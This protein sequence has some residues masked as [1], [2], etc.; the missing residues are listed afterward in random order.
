MEIEHRAVVFWSNLTRLPLPQIR[1]FCMATL[2]FFLCFFAW[3]GIAPLMK[4]VREDLQLTQQQVGWCIIASVSITVLARL[5]V[6]RLC[7]RYGPRKTYTLLLCGWSLPVMGIALVHD[8]EMFLIFRFLIGAVGAA[9]VVTQYHTT[10]MFAPNVVGTANATAAAWGNLGG[11]VTQIA[12]PALFSLLVGAFGLSAAAGW[13]AAMVLAGALCFLAGV[14]Y[15]R[16]TQDAPDGNFSELR[17]R[18]QPAGK[19]RRRAFGDACLDL[20]VW[21]LFLACAACF[22]LELTM[23]NLSA[24]Y[25][26]DCFGLTLVGAGTMAALFG[27]TNLFARTLGGQFSDRFG[28]T[29]GLRGRVFWLFLV[30]FAEG[31]MLMLFSQARHLSFAIPGLVLFAVL[32]QMST[33]ATFSVVPFVNK[34]ALGSVAGI[35][36]AGGNVGAVAA[37]FFFQGP[38]ETWPVALLTLGAVVTLA[39]F[40]VFL[41]RFSTAAESEASRDYRAA[42]AS[43]RQLLNA[44]AM[45]EPSQA[46]A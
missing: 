2:S 38:A 20:R 3:F 44:G 42:L 15:W 11:G 19:V 30:L 7:D 46:G 13:R 32:V 22:G 4:V 6:G 40:S 45:L 28:G 39:S 23:K 21:A 5:V 17:A 10:V 29:W 31:L 12:M 18:G 1:A 43:R 35:V 34:R 26:A 25:F 33:G 8:C 14:A 41:V 37:G 27:S 16:L 24:L 9:L 36:G